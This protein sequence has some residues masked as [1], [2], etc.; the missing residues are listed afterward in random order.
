MK[1]TLHQCRVST[2]WGHLAR[3]S[4]RLPK[5]LSSHGV[6]TGCTQ[7]TSRRTSTKALPGGLCRQQLCQLLLRRQAL[8]QTSASCTS[9]SWRWAMQTSA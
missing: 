7:T 8:W 2:I 3:Q 4:W 9:P 1:L 6:R 5:M